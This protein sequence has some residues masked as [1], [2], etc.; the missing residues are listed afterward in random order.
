MSKLTSCS[1]RRLLYT[2]KKTL[3]ALL[4]DAHD[5]SSDELT[6]TPTAVACCSTCTRRWRLARSWRACEK[7]G[8][9]ASGLLNTSPCARCPSRVWSPGSW[10]YLTRQ[11]IQAYC[12]GALIASVLAWHVCRTQSAK[13]PREGAHT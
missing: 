6:G 10:P 13:L 9:A 4:G 2:E 5:G 11:S 7:S 3:K 1:L 12:A 8:L